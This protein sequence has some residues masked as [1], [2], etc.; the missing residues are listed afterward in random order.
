MENTSRT[1][2]HYIMQMMVYVILSLVTHPPFYSD[3][4]NV[5][6]VYFVVRTG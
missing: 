3:S 4:G 6:S 5:H 1:T 2:L